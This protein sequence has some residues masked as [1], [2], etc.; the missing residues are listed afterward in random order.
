MH[1][2]YSGIRA[3]TS[4]F[5]IKIRS[6]ERISNIE[7]I[8]KS[9]EENP[10]CFVTTPVFFKPWAACPFHISD[11]LF[12]GDT[13]IFRGSYK[14]ICDAYDGKIP[15][16]NWMVRKEQQYSETVHCR[17]F[18]RAI[19]AEHTKESVKENFRIVSYDQLGEYVIS[20]G[21]NGTR[22][23][24][25]ADEESLNPWHQPKGTWGPYESIYCIEDLF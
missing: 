9:I 12:G 15:F 21:A 1:S 14:F 17:G 20:Y 13:E 18:L 5:F 8:I 16:E 4:K 10:K 19:G 11:H 22:W 23:S 25:C 3:C 6:D 2:I 7:P 24:N